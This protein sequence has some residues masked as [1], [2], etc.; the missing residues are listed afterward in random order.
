M[1]AR[2]EVEMIARQLEGSD[3]P[4]KDDQRK[5]LVAVFTEERATGAEPRNSMRAPTQRN[6]RRPQTNGR[7]TTNSA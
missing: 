5:R 6:T 3:V 7:T 1:P 4:L 2:G